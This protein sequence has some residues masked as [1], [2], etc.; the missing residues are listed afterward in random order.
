V[1][2]LKVDRRFLPK[3]WR[4]QGDGYE[5][6]QVI[7]I[8]ISRFVTEYRAQV[9]KDGQVNRFFAAFPDRVNRSVQYGIGIKG[10]AV[11]ML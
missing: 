8:D 7:D 3:G 10:N 9:V 5:A 6:R 1:K 4:D 2:K 11:Y